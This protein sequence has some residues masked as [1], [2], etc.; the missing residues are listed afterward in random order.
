MHYETES[1][2]NEYSVEVRFTPDPPM[3]LE[4]FREHIARARAQGIP[5]RIGEVTPVEGETAFDILFLRTLTAD[6]EA[7]EEDFPDDPLPSACRKLAEL[8]L[9]SCGLPFP[10]QIKEVRLVRRSAATAVELPVTL[11]P[12]LMSLI[13]YPGDA[14]YVMLFYNCGKAT[15]TDGKFIGN[16][17]YYAALQPLKEHPVI[18]L[19]LHKAKAQIGYDDLAATHALI[20]DRAER[21][22]LL[23]GFDTACNL[24]AEQHPE[25]AAAP[26]AEELDAYEELNAPPQTLADLHRRGSMEFIG[27]PDP[28]LAAMTWQLS[29]WLDQYIT[30]QVVQEITD[31][32]RNRDLTLYTQI[33][34]LK[35]WIERQRK[36]AATPGT[37]LA[38]D[39]S[40][41]LPN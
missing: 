8:E 22:I 6:D 27:T 3:Q 13:R 39:S 38:E 12:I 16:F 25:E 11:P 32:I 26:D 30:E 36:A 31:A 15:Y 19:H 7:L 21:K 2:E 18:A 4:A 37:P 1:Y 20:C 35:Q 40:H 41:A 5:G 24:V 33:A 29:A 9:K 17:P 10:F 23:A 34:Y 28:A 14:R